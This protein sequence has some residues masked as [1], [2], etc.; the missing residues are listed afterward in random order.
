MDG[1]L[2]M[3]DEEE[4]EEEGKEVEGECDCDCDCKQITNSGC[5]Q[6]GALSAL[7]SLKI[8]LYITLYG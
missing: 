7:G 1:I 3:D 8:V 4:E 2:W 6:G 5:L